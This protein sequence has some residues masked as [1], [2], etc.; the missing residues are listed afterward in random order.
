MAIKV[1]L[2]WE[3][4]KHISIFY[5]TLLG[6]F[7]NVEKSFRIFVALWHFRWSMAHIFSLVYRLILIRLR[8]I[9]IKELRKLSWPKNQ[10]RKRL[11]TQFFSGQNWEKVY[12]SL[13]VINVSKG[14]SGPTLYSLWLIS[15]EIIWPLRRDK[16]ISERNWELVSR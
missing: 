13:K 15:F 11:K 3:G 14:N 2:F 12:P 16:K 6:K 9:T 4:Q 5:L 7:K 10:K 8:V 1:K